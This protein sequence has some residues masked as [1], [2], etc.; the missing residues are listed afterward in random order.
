MEDCQAY[1]A[2]VML[3]AGLP[4]VMHYW[5]ECELCTPFSKKTLSSAVPV[6]ADTVTHRPKMIFTSSNLML[7]SNLRLRLHLCP[8]LR[9]RPHDSSYHPTLT[10]LGHITSSGYTSLSLSALSSYTPCQRI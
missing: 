8:L 3:V 9:C 2:D 10:A 6:C 4:E 5:H 1:P 7:L